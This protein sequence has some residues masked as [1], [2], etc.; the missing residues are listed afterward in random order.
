MARCALT[1][2]GRDDE[3]HRVATGGVGRIPAAYRRRPGGRAACHSGPA[4]HREEWRGLAPGRGATHGRSVGL[5]VMG[6]GGGT[7]GRA[8]LSR[9]APGH[10]VTRDRAGRGEAP[11]RRD[12]GAGG[13]MNPVRRTETCDTPSRALTSPGPADHPPATAQ[14]AG[15]RVPVRRTPPERAGLRAE[16]GL[17]QHC[18]PPPGLGHRSAP[19]YGGT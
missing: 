11:P 19:R 14:H 1:L 16:G 5:G 18:G 12:R 2:E 8:S 13:M 17:T 6:V 10:G 3:G 9:P 15:H 4:R 7:R